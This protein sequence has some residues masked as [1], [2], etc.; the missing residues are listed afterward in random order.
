MDHRF[1]CGGKLPS[2]SRRALPGR[3]GSKGC[4]SISILS[5]FIVLPA[6]V[7][8]ISWICYPAMS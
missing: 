3:K 2:I 8:N 7:R 4:C 5:N 1:F 6:K